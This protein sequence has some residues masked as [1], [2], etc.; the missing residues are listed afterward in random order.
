MK[1]N[2]RTNFCP[3]CEA[4]AKTIEDLQDYITA[5][6]GAVVKGEPT[7]TIKALQAKNAWLLETLLS[8]ETAMVNGS[9]FLCRSILRTALQ[10]MGQ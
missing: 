3:N 7:G 5:M 2:I 10:R 1:P 4:Q 8:A 9:P 6:R